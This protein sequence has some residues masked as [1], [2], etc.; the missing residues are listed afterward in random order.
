MTAR[1]RLL[2]FGMIATFAVVLVSGICLLWPQTPSA[3]NRENA[4]KIQPGMTLEEVE[5][6]LGGSARHD[7][8]G[9]VSSDSAAP[10]GADAAAA[11]RF[12]EQAPPNAV[13]FLR[14]GSETVTIDVLFDDAGRAL[15]PRYIFHH[16]APE[17]VLEKLRRLFNL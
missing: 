6:I 17:T 5:A 16:R 3:I 14:W 12:S 15:P 7:F 11:R 8:A 10:L 4:A 13:R 9:L 2:L 1:R